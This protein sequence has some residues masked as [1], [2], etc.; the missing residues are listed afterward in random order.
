[1]I[2]YVCG[3]RKGKLYGSDIYERTAGVKTDIVNGT[4]DGAFYDGEFTLQYCGQLLH[5]QDQRRCH[6]GIITGVSSAESG[7]CRDD[8]IW[9]R[10]QCGHLILPGS[11]G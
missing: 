10:N 5:R 6:D 8:R 4:A 11:S 2:C 1:M 3:K 9:N 7:Q